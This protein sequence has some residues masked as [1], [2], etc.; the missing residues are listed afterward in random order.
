MKNNKIKR[1]TGKLGCG[2]IKEANQFN[3]A[4]R[5][6]GRL[7]DQCRE[8][9]RRIQKEK[10]LKKQEE[11]K[12]EHGIIEGTDLCLT[13]NEVKSISEFKTAK[14]I[15][16]GYER[17]CKKCN[18]LKNKITYYEDIDKT[19]EKNRK[20]NKKHRQKP[21][22]KENNK[23]LSKQYFLDHP[24]YQSEWEKDHRKERRQKDIKYAKEHPDK[25][26]EK[27][28]KRRAKKQE[29]NENFTIQDEQFVYNLF[30]NECFNCKNK[31]NLGID[32]VRPLSKGN[33]LTIK[34]AC[35]LCRSC[36]ASKGDNEPEEFYSEFKL[37]ELIDILNSIN[38]DISKEADI[39]VEIINEQIC[40]DTLI[41][42]LEVKEN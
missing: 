9:C 12:K 20:Y 1:C 21:G 24:N 29:V 6:T 28:R 23:Q 33:A 3:F 10:T 40:Q 42:N 37:I 31:E 7:K 27:S 30:N 22:V 39:L 13:C 19:R 14:K 26:R 5:T 2:K 15:K 38:K 36:N 16:R 11:F 8:C 35:V 18:N 41:Q 17:I 4:N 25:M 32:H 34:N